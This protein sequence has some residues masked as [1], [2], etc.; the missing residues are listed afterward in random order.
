MCD[1]MVGLL[2]MFSD[3]SVIYEPFSKLKSISGKSEIESFLRTTIMANKGMEQEVRIEKREQK[4]SEN[5][6]VA[7]VTFHKGS[8]I[9]CRFT[10]ELKGQDEFDKGTIKS[11]GID[12]ID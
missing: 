9:K 11:L 5:K 12:F 8:S 7:L 4:T 2:K 3:D 10:F 1:D 6:V